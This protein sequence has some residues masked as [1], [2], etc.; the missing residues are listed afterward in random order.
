VTGTIRIASPFGLFSARSEAELE[1]LE[2][3]G[4][5]GTRGRASRGRWKRW[6][7]VVCKWRS[8]GVRLIRRCR[9]RRVRRGESVAPLRV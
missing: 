4:V 9:V 7:R 1:E 2:D 8:E 6:S 3:F 5:G